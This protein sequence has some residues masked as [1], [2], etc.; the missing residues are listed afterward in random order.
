MP[1]SSTSI[2]L[3]ILIGN[4]SIVSRLGSVKRS[5]HASGSRRFSCRRDLDE[6]LPVAV[7]ELLPVDLDLGSRDPRRPAHI[8]RSWGWR[9]RCRASGAAGR[10]CRWPRRS[11]ASASGRGSGRRRSRRGC[12]RRGP[13][14]SRARAA[15]GWS[16]SAASTCPCRSTCPS[17]CR[18]GSARAAPVRARG[19]PSARKSVYWTTEVVGDGLERD[20]RAPDERDHRRPAAVLALARAERALRLHH[21]E[22][23]RR[24]VADVELS[25]RSSRRAAAGSASGAARRRTA[26]S[27][28]RRR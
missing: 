23:L 7:V 15:R 8:A 13:C 1:A 4:E 5:R 26:R 22:Q 2:W 16:G 24:D 14:G 9:G 18:P 11:R 19:V 20:R 12:R 21:L 3:P 25:S 10:R 27:A 28:A 6:L 17:P